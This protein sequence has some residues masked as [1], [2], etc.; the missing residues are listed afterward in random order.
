MA[1]P[2]PSSFLSLLFLFFFLA[3]SLFSSDYNYCCWRVGQ[4]RCVSGK[5]SVSRAL[6]MS[7]KMIVEMKKEMEE[8]DK[9]GKRWRTMAEWEQLPRVPSGPDP[10]H[11]NGGSPKKPR[12]P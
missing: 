8:G 2:S 12:T 1:S 7:R 4:C 3:H 5:L 10:L 9:G 6:H 11:H